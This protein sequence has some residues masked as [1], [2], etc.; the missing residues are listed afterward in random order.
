MRVIQI[1]GAYPPRDCG[2]E[3]YTVRLAAALEHHGL[4]VDI[5]AGGG[6]SLSDT[7]SLI[8]KVS[9]YR[10]HVVHVQ[11]PTGN[12]GKSLVPQALA[13]MMPRVPVITTIHEF[14]ESHV[15]RKV[16][17]LPFAL[18][19]R[20][21]VFTSEYERRHFLSWFPWVRKRSVV[22]PIGSNIPFSPGSVRR[23]PWGVVY[24]GLI[25]PHKGLE[26]F[27]ELARLARD[28]GRPYRFAIVGDTAAR[29]GSYPET[30]KE[31]AKDLPVGWRIGLS[32]D[33]VSRS[34]AGSRFAYIPYPDGASERRGSLLAA[35]GN[36]TAMITTE[37][38][39]TPEALRSS[40]CFAANPSQAL[41]ALDQLASDVDRADALSARAI[42]YA[43]RASWSSIALA[44]RRLYERLSGGE[45]R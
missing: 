20:A 30:L 15:L 24:F 27:L 41:R 39:Q 44:H 45:P 16:A 21:L 31:R 29:Y 9:G 42:E 35:L 7:P 23:D 43:E 6:R 36:G 25:R 26:E 2:A 12:Y 34:L 8:K 13:T 33:E 17:D 1:V 32:P 37:G 22:V 28:A 19:G 3:D 4:E 38:P 18:R 40:V 11:Y 10:P 5:L 14:S